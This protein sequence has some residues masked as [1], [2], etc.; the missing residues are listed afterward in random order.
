MLRVWKVLTRSSWVMFILQMASTIPRTNSHM[1]NNKS[2]KNRSTP[3]AFRWIRHLVAQ[4]LP[5]RYM[6]EQK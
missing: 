1:S 3:S 5:K 6:R 2:V 4:L